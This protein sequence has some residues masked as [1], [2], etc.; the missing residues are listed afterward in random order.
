[1]KI[2][3]GSSEA[4]SRLPELLRGIQA[5]NQ[6]TITSRGAAVADLLPSTSN[7]ESD[8]L[9]A[10]SDMLA[11]MSER[12]SDSTGDLRALIEEGRE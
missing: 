5:G 10:V 8:A 7:Q 12:Q 11:F 9:G 1:M 2:V 3:I 4:R 6:Y